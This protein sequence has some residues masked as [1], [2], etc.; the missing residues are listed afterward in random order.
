MLYT[1]DKLI[2]VSRFGFLK[3]EA[4]PERDGEYVTTQIQ[5]ENM[6]K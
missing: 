3:I 1:G 4:S 2:Y 6:E 5:Y